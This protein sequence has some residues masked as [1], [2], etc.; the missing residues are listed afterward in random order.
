MRLR[1]LINT[2]LSQTISV[3]IPYCIEWKM[4]KEYATLNDTDIWVC[5]LG[6]DFDS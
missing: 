5:D 6:H 1:C 2:M 4:S 3:K